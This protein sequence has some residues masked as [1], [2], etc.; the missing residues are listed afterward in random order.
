MT[1]K[2]TFDLFN[3]INVIFTVKKS[4]NMN[5]VRKYSYSIF[6]KSDPLQ[7]VLSELNNMSTARHPSGPSWSRPCVTGFI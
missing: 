1:E 6:I 4:S 2:S 5:K 7:S 3:E